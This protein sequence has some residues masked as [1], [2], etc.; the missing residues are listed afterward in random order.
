MKP[1]T[2]SMMMSL[3][4]S[5][6]PLSEDSFMIKKKVID[7]KISHNIVFAFRK[8]YCIAGNVVSVGKAIP[9]Q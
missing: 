5:S 4:T 2:T 3:N 7:G 8:L 9:T 6:L 1:D